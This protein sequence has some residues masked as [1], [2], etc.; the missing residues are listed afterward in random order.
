M[1]QNAGPFVSTALAALTGASD[2]LFEDAGYAGCQV[3]F[4]SNPNAANPIWVNPFGNA[5]VANGSGSVK[6]TAGE[7]R[8][9]QCTNKITVIGTAADKI[10][11]G[12]N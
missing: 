9:F 11:A 3:V 1:A 6:L 5:A 7:T 10:T 4:I 2:T 12:R 8:F